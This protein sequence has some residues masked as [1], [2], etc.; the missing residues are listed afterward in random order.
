[1]SPR[2]DESE[3]SFDGSDGAEPVIRELQLEMV[4]LQS[5]IDQL[6]ASTRDRAGEI[7]QL[8]ARLTEL[9]RRVQAL[10]ARFRR[11][12]KL[13]VWIAAI[14]GAAVG[15]AMSWLLRP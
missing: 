13:W 7:T 12:L 14:Y 2:D 11:D 6:S 9:E 1:M 15:V 5:Q 10:K 4:R 8:R 3:F